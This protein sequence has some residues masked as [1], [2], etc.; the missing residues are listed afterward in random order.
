MTAPDPAELAAW[1]AANQR[2]RAEHEFPRQPERR[3]IP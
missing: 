3:L 2:A 1:N